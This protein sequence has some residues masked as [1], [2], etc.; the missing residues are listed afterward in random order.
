MERRIKEK[1]MTFFKNNKYCIILLSVA[2]LSSVTLTPLYAGQNINYAIENNT[3]TM[4]FKDNN[5][6]YYQERQYFIDK[7]TIII[8][9]YS[10]KTD[11]ASL[12]FPCIAKIRYRVGDDNR[13]V[14]E[15]IVIKRYL[16]K[17]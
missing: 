6:F 15:K 13:P 14:C 10:K 12:K 9:R 5:S 4:D 8:D 7:K 17:K 16:K 11:F 2:L 3:L 1:L